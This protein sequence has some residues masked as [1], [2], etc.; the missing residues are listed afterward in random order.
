MRTLLLLGTAALIAARPFPAASQT[1]EL[2]WP[3]VS[4]SARLDADGRL[5]VVERQIMR[6]TGDWNGGQR[7]F[8][9]RRGD[10]FTFERISRVNADGT[11]R[12]LERGDLDRVDGYDWTDGNTLRWRSRLPSDP[13]FDGTE[14]TYQ[15]EFSY[16]SILQIRQDTLYLLAH[17]FAFAEREGVFSRFEVEIDVDSAWGVPEGWSGRFYAIDLPPGQ[18]FRVDVPLTREAATRPAGVH[19]G[20]APLVRQ[21]LL[22]GLV[23]ALVGLFGALVRRE[24][25][26]GRLAP[27]DSAETVTPEFLRE[28]V[29]AQLPEVVGSEWDNQTSAPEV[30]ATLARL[31]Q[32]RKL[33]S[34]VR[35]KKAWVFKSHVLEL[36]LLEPRSR[37]HDHE[38]ALID[39]L[40]DPGA[41]TTD[42]ERV[43]ERYKKTGFDP[44][45]V[46]RGRLTT[47]ADGM[48]RAQGETPSRIPTAVLLAIAIVLL[49]IGVAA[50]RVDA[51]PALAFVFGSFPVYVLAAAFAHHWRNRVHGF[52][53]GALGFL[54]PLI[55]LVSLFGGLLLIDG[56]FRTGPFV[57][58]GLTVWM[59]GIANSVFNLARSRQSTG[60]I[61]RR[62]RLAAAREYFREELAKARPELRD[63]WFPY[64]LAFG[65]GRHIDRWFESFGG[66]AS[67]VATRS[68]G[69]S[70]GM[71]GS[72]GGGGSW[73]GFGGGGGFGGAGGGASFGAVIGGM[74]SAVPAPGSSSGGGGGGGGGGGS[75]G[76]G[77]GG[78]W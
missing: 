10:E 76:G 48:T 22:G 63:E 65:L 16:G 18:G 75:S 58:A 15:L 43:R 32:E 53:R 14:L 66:E 71:G 42:T 61:A 78:G 67:T 12:P 31:V 24:R 5:H 33:A 19:F 17:D 60:R 52:V 29:F 44:A 11:L 69:Y 64:V 59:I 38:R 23:V 72:T 34:T 74:A 73:T 51:G 70:S 35:T 28:H 25:R 13:P 3:L 7:I 2:T 21:S 6:F 1:R 40:F 47:I 36:R 50:R 68:A 9:N 55:A 4:V 56:R 30:A 20:T 39:A 49:I 41:N 27:I 45:S 26:I 37:F 62:K 77:G 46:I 54:I 8:A 57:L